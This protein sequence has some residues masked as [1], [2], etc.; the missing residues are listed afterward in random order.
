MEHMTQAVYSVLKGETRSYVTM[1]KA[2]LFFDRV[3]PDEFLN[4]SK[5]KILRH[6]LEGEKNNTQL[7]NL[8]L[9]YPTIINNIRKMKTLELVEKYGNFNR[10]TE[11]GKTVLAQ[12]ER[13]IQP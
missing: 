5:M 4:D 6:L 9:S 10:I 7:F 13:F 3:P 12:W 1:R 11:K 2:E 8:G